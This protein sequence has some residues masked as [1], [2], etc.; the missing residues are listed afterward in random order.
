MDQNQRRARIINM[1]QGKPLRRPTRDPDAVTTYSYFIQSRPH[2]DAEWERPSGV[3]ITWASKTKALERLGSRREMQPGWE[4]R[5]ME[6]ITMVTER[7]ATE[8]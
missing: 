3:H 7:P 5:L 4:H 6:R 2:A 1:R 8:D